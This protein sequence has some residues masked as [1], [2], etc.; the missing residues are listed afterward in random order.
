MPQQIPVGT[1][2]SLS[3]RVPGPHLISAVF[4]KTELPPGAGSSYRVRAGR[5]HEIGTG[6]TCHGAGDPGREHPF[7][8]RK[9]IHMKGVT[10]LSNSVLL[11]RSTGG[12]GRY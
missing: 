4:P 10:S 8:D 5:D 7:P 2:S 12:A 1:L 11:W 6:G 3:A 9:A